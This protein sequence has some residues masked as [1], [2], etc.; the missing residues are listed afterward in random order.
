LNEAENLQLKI[1]KHSMTNEP[2]AHTPENFGT[3]P[4]LQSLNWA[5]RIGIMILAG[6]GVGALTVLGQGSLPGS[7]NHFANSGAMWLLAAFLIGAL[8][9][10]YRWAAPAGVVTLFGAL[11][12]YT[13]TT[14]TIG[15]AYTV[16]AFA[17]W[18]AVGLVGGPVFGAAGRGWRSPDIRLRVIGLALLGG[19]F[20]AE[21]WYYM[22]RSLQDFLAG[23]LFIAIGLLLAVLLARSNKERL[24]TLL[25][26]LPITMVGIGVYALI[27]GL[28]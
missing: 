23:W 3:V 7:W 5:Q 1:R 22:N 20:A 13:L 9:P 24:Y 15:Y 18:G 14:A 4:F 28:I 2:A 16:S 19:V 21:G 6:L 10:S 26:M 12:G 11:A 17:F 25:V 27:G 8:M